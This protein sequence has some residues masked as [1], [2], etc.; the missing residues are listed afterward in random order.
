MEL[1]NAIA[2]YDQSKFTVGIEIDPEQNA[3]FYTACNEII[4][5]AGMTA[6]KA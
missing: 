3:K 2:E 5:K 4:N 1:H 6:E